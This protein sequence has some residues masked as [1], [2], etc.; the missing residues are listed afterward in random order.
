MR[1]EV[2][3]SMMSV[4]GI[5]ADRVAAMTK[6]TLS[7]ALADPKDS[8]RTATSE[9]RLITEVFGL[10]SSFKASASVEV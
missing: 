2:H 10:I 4:H 9:H 3:D 8:P 6:N 1:E 5:L 7:R